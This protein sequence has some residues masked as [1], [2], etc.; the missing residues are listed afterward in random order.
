MCKKKGVLMIT[1]KKLDKNLTKSFHKLYSANEK[2]AWKI[3]NPVM[4]E[5]QKLDLAIYRKIYSLRFKKEF[6]SY[7]TK[8]F[9]YRSARKELHKYLQHGDTTILKHCRNVAYFSFTC[10]KFLEKKFHLH[11]DYEAL[12]IGAY[13]HDFF[14][15]DWHQKDKTHRLHGFSHPRTASANAQELCHINAKE[16]SIIESHMWPLTITKIPK[17]KEAFLVCL[18][19]KYAAILETFKIKL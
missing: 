16:Q 18:F 10:A 3:T 15:Y 5:A 9:Y 8:Q 13:L 4:K 2:E 7:I 19:D 6:Y 12:I 1:T 14:M 17:S 11:F